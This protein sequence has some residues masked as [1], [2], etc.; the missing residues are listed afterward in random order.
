MAVFGL[1]AMSARASPQRRTDDAD[2]AVD[3]SILQGGSSGG[4]VGPVI[5]KCPPY[6]PKAR[7]IAEDELLS[8]GK[9]HHKPH[10]IC[11]TYDVTPKGYEYA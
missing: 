8:G 10:L 6:N 11:Y 2:L 9:P 4:S 7:D 3:D 1:V 5:P